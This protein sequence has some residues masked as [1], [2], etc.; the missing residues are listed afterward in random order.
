[1]SPVVTADL[2]CGFVGGLLVEFPKIYQIRYSPRK[3]MPNWLSS[4]YFWLVVL[5]MAFIGGGLVYLQLA[6]G[7]TLT[8]WA[9][10]NIGLSAP[11]VVEKGFKTTGKPLMSDSDFE[12]K[13]Q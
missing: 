10:F 2:I 13:G 1:M 5:T 9:A 7:S 11:L 12:E 8:D 4:P 6:S 3:E